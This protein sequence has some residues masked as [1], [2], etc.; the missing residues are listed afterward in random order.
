MCALRVVI[1]GGL[2]IFASAVVCVYVW[3]QKAAL[4]CASVCL[5]CL[6]VELRQQ[7]VE[8]VISRSGW[9]AMETNSTDVTSPP[10][11]APT[12][13]ITAIPLRDC[14]Q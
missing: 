2:Y 7:Q 3:L 6:I 11:W 12:E 13:N 8:L 4:L 10:G 14:L 5:F 9:R 1:E